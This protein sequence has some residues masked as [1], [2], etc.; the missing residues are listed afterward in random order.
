MAFQKVQVTQIYAFLCLSE[1]R[2]V[3]SIFL[4]V[5][6]FLHESFENLEFSSLHSCDSRRNEGE[7]KQGVV[8]TPSKKN[9][10]NKKKVGEQYYNS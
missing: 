7:N 4:L 9:Q 5:N 3:G 8:T 2:Y 6:K 10:K 1:D